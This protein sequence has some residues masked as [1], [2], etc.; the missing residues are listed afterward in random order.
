MA[1]AQECHQEVRAA[2]TPAPTRPGAPRVIDMGG[3]GIDYQQESALEADPRKHAEAD[4]RK[5]A[6]E[7]A[8]QP[9]NAAKETYGNGKGDPFSHGESAGYLALVPLE[10]GGGAA[11]RGASGEGEMLKKADETEAWVRGMTELAVD[12]VAR[13]HREQ[14]HAAR[15]AVRLEGE[16]SGLLRRVAEL[17]GDL[18][19]SEGTVAELRAECAVGLV[20]S[21]RCAGL[22]ANSL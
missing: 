4:P 17:E 19:E 6:T 3:A 21:T 18:Q 9:R 20:K 8:K 11:G 22:A 10:A 7:H 16:V 5:H 12:G 15:A 13:A 2:F 14:Y 1:A